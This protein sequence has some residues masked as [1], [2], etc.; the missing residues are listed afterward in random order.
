MERESTK[1]P[2]VATILIIVVLIFTSLNIIRTITSLQ[3]WSF[4]ESLPLQ[5]PVIYLIISGLIWA[6]LGFF[7][8]ISYVL[9]K[10]WTLPLSTIMFI[11]YPTYYWID[12][13]FISKRTINDHQWRFALALTLLSMIL[14]FWISN[15]SKTKNYF[16]K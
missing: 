4:L 9:K 8:L 10:K 3:S 6:L 5:I 16:N 7:L 13:L 2:F 11:G 14:G 1:R 15:D 12:R